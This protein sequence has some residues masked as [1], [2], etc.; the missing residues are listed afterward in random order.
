MGRE[1]GDPVLRDRVVEPLAVAN[2]LR[3]RHDVGVGPETVRQVLKYE[4]GGG[5]LAHADRMPHFGHDDIATSIVAQL[6]DGGD[7]QGGDVE[8]CVDDEVIRLPR[9]RGVVA[10]FDSTVPHRVLEVTGGTR[11]SL[12]VF[13]RP[14][15][16]P[17]PGDELIGFEPPNPPP[18]ASLLTVCPVIVPPRDGLLDSWDHPQHL[19]VVNGDVDDWRQRCQER[20]WSYLL[21]RYS[22]NV[23]VPASWNLA[24][25]R[26]K[27]VGATHVAILSQ[28]T[29]LA[30]GTKHLAWLVAKR[31]HAPWIEISGGVGQRFHCIVV[32]VAVWEHVGGFDETLSIWCDV[33]FMRRLWLSG[34]GERWAPRAVRVQLPAD[35]LQNSAV[36]A[37]VVPAHVYDVD[38]QRYTDKWGGDH[39]A[40]TFARPWDPTSVSPD[41]ATPRRV[42]AHGGFAAVIQTAQLAGATRVAPGQA[43]AVAPVTPSASVARQARRRPGRS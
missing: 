2:T 8:F 26:A 9:T 7:Y 27:Q 23:G 19:V 16:F 28:G 20:G 5:M 10:V 37:G 25:H 12:T 36:R 41:V 13:G 21:D 42:L 15:P 30:G 22:R 32:S 14:S 24:F 40:E 4:I 39:L 17:P 18:R 38:R 34:R 33:D 1:I 35:D 29:V 11:Y 31:P 43:S 6:S 3:W